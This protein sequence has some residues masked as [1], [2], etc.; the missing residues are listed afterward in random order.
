M[1]QRQ[2]RERERKRGTE[3]ERERER[4]GGHFSLGGV[5]N[6]D[7]YGEVNKPVWPGISLCDK[8]LTS[9]GMLISVRAHFMWMLDQALMAPLV[10]G[11]EIKHHMS[12]AGAPQTWGK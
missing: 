5:G 3:R 1:T 9:V 12:G 11:H 7:N 4:E 6:E 2:E 10:E 8:P